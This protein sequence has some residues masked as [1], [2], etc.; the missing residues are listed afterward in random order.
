MPYRVLQKTDVAYINF[1][2]SNFLQTFIT[3]CKT[4]YVSQNYVYILWENLL[5]L[6]YPSAYS[7]V[8]VSCMPFVLDTFSQTLTGDRFVEAC[9]IHLYSVSYPWKWWDRNW[10]SA[11]FNTFVF[12]II[13]TMVIAFIYFTYVPLAS[14]SDQ[15]EINSPRWCDPNIDESLVR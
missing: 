3:N 14:K 7:S 4:S 11:K 9:W 1:R 12:I 10:K 6:L 8:W 13:K 5:F 15:V 2:F